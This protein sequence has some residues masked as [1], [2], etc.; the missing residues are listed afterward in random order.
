MN[1][2]V[3]AHARIGQGLLLPSIEAV[4]VGDVP[5]GHIAGQGVF[6]QALD[7]A[8]LLILCGGLGPTDDD[9]TREAVVP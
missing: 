2:D 7:R 5:L 3:R 1:I 4:V 6:R 9:L 8:D